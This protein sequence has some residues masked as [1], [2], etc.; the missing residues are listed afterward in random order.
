MTLASNAG[1]EPR[2]QPG[3]VSA[4][5]GPY[6]VSS[7]SPLST[8]RAAC[9]A[10]GAAP[11]VTLHGAAM[12]HPLPWRRPPQDFPRVCFHCASIHE[13]TT[14]RGQLARSR[15]TVFA[16][17]SLSSVLPQARGLRPPSSSWGRRLARPP[18]PPPHPSLPEALGF[19]WGLPSLLP[20][21]LHI[22]Q[23]GSRVRH[24]RLK[25]TDV[26][27]VWLAFPLRALRLPRLPPG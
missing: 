18:T 27:G 5:R 13:N 9:T 23:A 2:Q 22:Q 14:S 8:G 12:Q 3:W 11:V 19:R 16:V 4:R 26:G 17:Y 15:G 25:Q 20:T 1:G 21:P 6:P 7:R 10:A 24:G